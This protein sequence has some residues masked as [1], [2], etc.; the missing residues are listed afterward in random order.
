MQ[1]S[2]GVTDNPRKDEN[3]SGNIS[4][5]AQFQIK[6]YTLTYTAGPGGS[7]S[8]NLNQTV[9]HGTDGTEVKAEPDAGYNFM[10]WSDEV[11][12]NPRKD[13]NITRNISVTANFTSIPPTAELSGSTTI[14]YGSS[15]TLS[16]TLTGIRPW[17]IVYN[18]GVNNLTLTDIQSSPHT[19]SV[20]PLAT[21]TYTLVSVSDAYAKEGNA[22]GS[23]VVTVNMLTVG[24]SVTGE[25]SEILLTQPTGVLTLSGHTG[26][27]VRWE[28]QVNGGAWTG[29]ANT[30]TTHSETPS[31]TGTYRF[32][33]V[34]I[35]GVCDPEYS[36][37]FEI[38]VS[39]SPV[40]VNAFYDASNGNIVINGQYFTTSQEIDVT[41]L[42]IS[43]GGKSFTLSS[44]T[45]NVNPS[46][47]TQAT[48]VVTG[49]DKAFL[50]WILNI[51]GFNSI[52]GS[53]YN[54]SAAESWN[55]PA[56]ADHTTPLAVSSFLPPSIGSA[57]YNKLESTL[58]V[59]ASRLAAAPEPVKD[60]DATKFTISGKDNESHTLTSASPDVNVISETRFI[61]NIGEADKA[62]I[63]QILDILGTSSSTG[64]TYNLAAAE[65]WN[66]P[67]HENYGIS[68]P[69]NPIEAIEIENQ[70]PQALD[71]AITGSPEIGNTI[72]GSYTYFDPEADPEEDSQYA[73]YRADDASGTGETLI[74]GASESQYTIT[75][76]DAAKYL[77]F[78]VTP[79][80]EIGKSPGETVKSAWVEVANSPPAAFDIG[81]TGR[82]EVGIE[83]TATYQYFDP[84]GDPEGDTE[85][86]WYRADDDSGSNEQEI[87]RG[88][89]YTLLLEDED[90]YIRITV[91]PFAAEG[92]ME[93]VPVPANYY[94]PV[95][96]TLPTVSLTGPADLCQGSIADII[97][98]LT[99]TAPWAV[100]YTDGT[101]ENNFTATASPFVLTVSRGGIYRVTRII[102]AEGLEGTE[103]GEELV[104][105]SVHTIL[106]E[107]W[108]TEIF[109]N[110][111]SGWTSFSP[112]SG[113]VNSWIFGLPDGDIFTSASEG[114]NIWYTDITNINI[115]EQSFVTSPCFDFSELERPMIAIDLWKE[116]GEDS[117]GAV[118]QYSINNDG[119]WKNTGMV[120]QGINWYNSSQITGMP[121]GQQ[122]GWTATGTQPG[123][124]GWI[125]SRHDLDVIAGQNY[126][127]FRIA[128]GSDG[129][130]QSQGG[131][132]FAN[133]RIGDRTRLVLLEHFTNANDENSIAANKI[134]NDIAESKKHDVA[135]I[136]YHT[137]FPSSD[138]INSQNTS[139]PAARALYYG[140]ST[141]PFSVMDGGLNGEGRYNYSPARFNEI[142]M[143]RRALVQPY[144]NIG[145]SQNQVNNDLSIEV[146]VSSVFALGP[147][148]L[149]LHVA[150]LETEIPGSVIGLG[151]DI[152]FRNVVR[153]LLPDAGGTFLPASWGANQSES[154][155]F[156]WT[157]DNIFDSENLALVAFIQDENSREVYQVGTSSEFG[158]PT[159]VDLP[160]IDFNKPGLV[161]YPNP[162]T[163]YLFIEFGENLTGDHILEIYNLSGYMVRTEILK[164]GRSNYEISTESLQRGVYLFSIRNNRDTVITARILIMK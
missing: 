113:M 4:V 57:I 85:I 64:H 129:S 107:D 18:D 120:G 46:S 144:F 82:M 30:T 39:D 48:I 119:N 50:N 14:C 114:S 62:A 159:F 161:F 97:F 56:L 34:V 162:A 125:D 3:V 154:Y 84:E 27:I 8:G 51:N 115:A 127:R 86:I 66:R 90:K 72:T 150:I 1:W 133:I 23:A 60:I 147:L 102:D 157:I 31:T 15:A 47:S 124:N 81:I 36:E 93:G 43:G 68:D 42:T 163:D 55:G 126:I 123:E 83:L 54:I 101:G 24:G 7:I 65:G 139:D 106:I 136:S 21:K 25:N 94:G 80:A 131:L 146:E 32:R 151:G 40:I 28:R 5:T 108:Y 2:D 92:T 69:T 130:G 156:N 132:A 109:D 143:I 138:P 128:Y 99:G 16:I 111:A 149:T 105:S 79:V 91:T 13:E 98:E 75:V 118:L 95:K 20:S 19:F 137:A 41:K 59:T 152:V 26:S 67:V 145:I 117:D 61:I 70:P 78:E 112:S 38:D 22:Q 141:V 33:A 121:G 35:S 37:P 17:E 74:Q 58:D 89:Q 142:D 122:T 160:S 135:Y 140:A 29:I 11:T 103:L 88:P 12:D 153:K 77:A 44:R 87:H 6:T 100:F 52:E 63:D 164:G 96:N 10:Q 134:V 110:G 104:I 158:I 49:K 71:V 9:N 155:S 53:P 76:E 45:A 73:W 116:F 148:D